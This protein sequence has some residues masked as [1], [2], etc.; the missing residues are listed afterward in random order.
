MKTEQIK[1]NFH[2]LI[3]KIDNERIL[4]KFY[5]LMLK[6]NQSTNGSLWNLLTEEEQEELLLS[7]FESKDEDN[8]IPHAEIQKKHKKWL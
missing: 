3:D 2:R 8:L 5:E 7:D 1:S 4:T 6:S